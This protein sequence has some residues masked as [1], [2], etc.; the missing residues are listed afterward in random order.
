MLKDVLGALKKAGLADSSYVVS[1]DQAVLA[2]AG[3]LGTRTIPDMKDSGVNSA[4]E[5]ATRRIRGAADFL[6]LPADL[7]TIGPADLEEILE[8]RAGGIDVGI[9]PS[10]AFD[11]TNALLFPAE[12]GF[13]LSYD[14]NSF[15]NHLA[16]AARM[17]V[18]VGVCTRVGLMF[19]VD[20]PE[21]LIRLAASGSGSTSAEFAKE[22]LE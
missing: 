14:R 16:S 13:P 10:L 6:V 3:K 7:P 4:V 2:Y 5:T 11:G 20:S 18:S 17:R 15:W 12:S 21:D 19:D 8:L 22:V 1:S 9:A